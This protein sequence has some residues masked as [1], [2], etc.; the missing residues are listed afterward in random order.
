MGKRFIIASK[1]SAGAAAEAD[2]TMHTVG[3]ARRLRVKRLTYYFSANTAGQLEISII[4]GTTKEIPDVGVLLGDV[5]PVAIEVDVEYG[6][7]SKVVVHYK[8]NDAV[9]A[10][11]AFLVLEG[12]LE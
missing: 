8:N 12:D 11:D 5:E 10:H 7:N 6:P 9:N 2:A 3:D 1:V 4:R